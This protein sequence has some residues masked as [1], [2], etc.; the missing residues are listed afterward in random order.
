M[1][2]ITQLLKWQ[3]FYSIIVR[4]RDQPDESEQDMKIEENKYVPW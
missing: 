2:K 3:S 1:T 4:L